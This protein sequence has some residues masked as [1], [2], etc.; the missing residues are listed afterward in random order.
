[1]TSEDGKAFEPIF[2]PGLTGLS[3]LGNSCYMASTVQT[4]F[5]LPSF[6]SRYYAPA[7]TSTPDSTAQEHFRLCTSD[8]PANCLECQMYKLA[9]GLLSGRYSR[10]GPSSSFAPIPTSQLPEV[11][12]LNL[13]PAARHPTQDENVS[14]L[15]FQQGI[16]PG[17]FKALIGKGHPEFSTM[18]QQDSEEFFTHL[19]KLLRQDYR[20]RAGEDPTEVFRYGM[21]QRLQCGD[22]KRVRYRVDEHDIVSIVVPARE[23]RGIDPANGETGKYE[24]VQLE[25]CLELLTAPEA[26]GWRCPA[27]GSDVVA[28]K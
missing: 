17:M 9:D 19:L 25:E 15:A 3:N 27:C 10:P 1:M 28:N 2:G 18:K 6:R 22:C 5:S 23:R 14:P 4:L 8:S 20:N 11:P 24:D 13:D 12:A 7:H 26:L 16:K 21:E